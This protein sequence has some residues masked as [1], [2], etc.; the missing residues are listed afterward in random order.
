MALEV[1]PRVRWTLDAWNKAIDWARA[2][3]EEAATF[4][5]YQGLEGYFENLTA[6]A[7]RAVGFTA[8]YEAGRIDQSTGEGGG[9]APE[10]NDTSVS[11]MTVKALLE[12]LNERLEDLRRKM[13]MQIFVRNLAGRKFTLQVQ[14]SY[15]IGEIK[16]MMHN[17]EGVGHLCVYVHRNHLAS[18]GLVASNKANECAIHRVS[19]HEANTFLKGYKLIYR[20][21]NAAK[22]S[23]SL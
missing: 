23:L 3:P 14:P 13:G 9:H 19:N 16:N 20:V 5:K 18:G 15:T 22:S 17:R 10:S 7:L 2:R 8:L 1:K 12:K 4:L 6:N 11:R 21:F